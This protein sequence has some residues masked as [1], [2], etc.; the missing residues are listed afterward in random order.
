MNFFF[1]DCDGHFTFYKNDSLIKVSENNP[2]LAVNLKHA[3][4]ILKD[5]K[6]KRLKQTHFQFL[7][8]QYLLVVLIK[9]N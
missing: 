4:L 1:K 3:E 9:N 7:V 8:Y 6:K 2:L 5:L